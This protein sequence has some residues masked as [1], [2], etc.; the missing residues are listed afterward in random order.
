MYINYTTAKWAVVR[1]GACECDF[2]SSSRD[3]DTHQH[4]V[5]THTHKKNTQSKRCGTVISAKIRDWENCKITE[6]KDECVLRIFEGAIQKPGQSEE[7][8]KK[9]KTEE[10]KREREGED[11]WEKLK[12]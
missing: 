10:R 8:R 2:E 5:R 12:P 6:Q 3:V 4:T 1:A 11:L 7:E 9:R